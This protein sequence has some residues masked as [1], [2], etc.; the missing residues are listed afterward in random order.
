VGTVRTVVRRGWLAV[1]GPEVDAV[2]EAT[3]RHA[4]S[5]EAAAG[6]GLL[7]LLEALTAN[8]LSAAPGLAAC[9]PTPT[10]LRVVVRGAGV[11]VLPDGR[12]VHAAGRMP[13]LDLDVDVPEEGEV[14]L[15]GPEP[16]Q[17]RGWQRPARI[18]R[19]AD[20][21]RPESDA[22]PVEEPDA[23]PEPEPE[24]DAEAAAPRELEGT[25]EVPGP[26]QVMPA[27][28]GQSITG[29][30]TPRGRGR[31]P[32]DEPDRPMV[33][34]VLCAA[35]H[36]SPPGAGRCRT[37]GREVPSQ[38]PSLAPRPSLGVLR[39][40]TGGTVALDRGVLLGRAPRVGDEL[41]AGQRPHL[42]RVHSVDRDISRN[43]A[44]VVLDGWQVLVRDL[45]STN[46]T[47][48][49]LPGQKAVRLRPAEDR[50]IEPGATVTLAGEVELTYEVP[51]PN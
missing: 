18:S 14:V 38:Q 7:A 48:V 4:T 9:A 39:I 29:V 46:G 43:H 47:T 24:R 15:E 45:G 16:H 27:A 50:A 41:P 12:R 22:Q 1:S 40:S 21:A 36:P 49:T 23:E 3:D 17:P 13:W 11:V 19:P 42:V 5:L 2:V 33:L 37:C 32:E 30:P 34:A 25:V 26:T 31:H 44:E 6:D 10:G 8:G 28:S 51:D 20:D 35:G